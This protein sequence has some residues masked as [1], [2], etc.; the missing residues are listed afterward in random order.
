MPDA[1]A[2]RTLYA[3]RPHARHFPALPAQKNDEKR[4]RYPVEACC[5]H[6]L[7]AILTV[8]PT[9][10][11]WHI[12]AYLRILDYLRMLY[13]QVAGLEFPLAQGAARPWD[14][15]QDPS[16][17]PIADPAKHLKHGNQKLF[18]RICQPGNH[19]NKGIEME[20]GIETTQRCYNRCHRHMGQ[21]QSFQAPGAV[22][23]APGVHLMQP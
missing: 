2:E 11:T 12:L 4:V 20:I 14:A 15:F 19:I 10:S 23:G 6:P 13:L 1:L 7:E 5:S 18:E 16:A 22:L 3:S 8:T 9:T 21:C 17:S